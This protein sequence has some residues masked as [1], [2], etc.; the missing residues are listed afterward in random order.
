MSGNIGIGGLPTPVVEARV[1]HKTDLTP[2][3]FAAVLVPED[4]AKLDG[5]VVLNLT[6]EKMRKWATVVA[7]ACEGHE[8]WTHILVQ[9][10]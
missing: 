5:Y 1:E 9:H 4:G 3:G 6:D 2:N 7:S 10:L 8:Q